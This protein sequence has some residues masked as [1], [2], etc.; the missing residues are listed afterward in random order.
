MVRLPASN[1]AALSSLIIQQAELELLRGMRTSTSASST[2][3]AGSSPNNDVRR[4]PLAEHSVRISVDVSAALTTT[5]V[6][7]RSSPDVANATGAHTSNVDLKSDRY[8]STK[9]IENSLY[10][11]QGADDIPKAPPSST[12][13]T[14]SSLLLGNVAS[15]CF[16]NQISESRRALFCKAPPSAAANAIHHPGKRIGRLAALLAAV[17]VAYIFS[18]CV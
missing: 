14:L 12:P 6:V 13:L 4:P 3:D 9:V 7:A 15:Y 17:T 2:S 5:S 11:P 18:D 1:A 8:Q 16:V 10:E